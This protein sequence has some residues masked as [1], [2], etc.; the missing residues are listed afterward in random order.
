MGDRL[1][2]AQEREAVQAA[3]M[4]VKMPAVDRLKEAL[5]KV[6]EAG[7]ALVVL[8]QRKPPFN[9]A[10]KLRIGPRSRPLFTSRVSLSYGSTLEKRPERAPPARSGRRPRPPGRPVGI[11][12]GI[13]GRNRQRARTRCR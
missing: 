13:G 9:G 12:G 3:F 7:R 5:E 6:T 4:E 2:L 1:E 10:F 11:F 8:Q